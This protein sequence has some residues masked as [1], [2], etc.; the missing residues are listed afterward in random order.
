MDSKILVI[1][2]DSIILFIHRTMIKNSGIKAQVE[3]FLSAELALNYIM[4]HKDSHSF[5]LLLDINMPGM[6]GWELLDILK[7]SPFKDNIN[8]V[9]VTS[10]INEADR[11]KAY[12]YEQVHEYLTK[13]IKVAD[14]VSLQSH[15]KVGRFFRP[16]N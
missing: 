8:V 7:A 3:Y 15:K 4:E 2:D 12:T 14:F 10:S 13:P 9:M 6:N 1:D 5:L 11:T 16:S